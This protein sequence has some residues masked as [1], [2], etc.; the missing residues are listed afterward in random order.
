MDIVL[1][2]IENAKDILDLKKLAYQSEAE[3]YKDW[4]IQ[5][6]TQ[7]VKEIN[8]EF[9][10]TIEKHF[11]DVQR[12]KLFTGSKCF[13]NIHFYKRLGYKSFKEKN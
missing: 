9:I 8:S 5:P 11:A 7:T 6:L 1:A 13:R 3:I 12:Y 4:N 10:D 2:T